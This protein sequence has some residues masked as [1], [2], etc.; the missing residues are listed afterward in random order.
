MSYSS[1]ALYG[2]GNIG[3]AT[4]NS[5]GQIT[6]YQESS[7][8]LH[9][10]DIYYA[11]TQGSAGGITINAQTVSL[12]NLAGGTTLPSL[13]GLGTGGSLTINA[14]NI[15]L[16]SNAIQINQF[17]E[18]DLDASSAILLKGLGTQ[19]APGDATTT[20]SD[21]APIPASLSVGGK[22]V[23]TTPLITGASIPDQAVT[24][25]T[26]TAPDELIAVSGALTIQAPTN[27]PAG[28]QDPTSLSASLLMSGS[29]VTQSSGSIVLHSGSLDIQAT[30]QPAKAISPSM[31]PSMWAALRGRLTASSVIPT[32]AKS[33]SIPQR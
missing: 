4:V 7:L 29:S 14:Q 23:L 8:A 22:L 20:A 17:V 21:A 13:A 27:G 16:G 26:T 6:A 31:E 2:S 32:V 1:I 12:D 28:S 33:L 3:G 30:G 25:T 11:D 18:V 24:S 19:V 10:D 9:A 5:S 15:S